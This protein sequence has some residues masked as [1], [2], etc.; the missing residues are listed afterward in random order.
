MITQA[1][2]WETRAEY[3]RAIDLYLRVTNEMTN[4][5]ELL[6][7]V[8]TKALELAIKF[9]KDRALSIAHEVCKRLMEIEAY[10]TVRK[11]SL[12][13]LSCRFATISIRPDL[14]EILRY[15]DCKLFSKFMQ[16]NFSCT[17]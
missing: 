3:N 6:E 12:P 16:T 7:E 11:F 14:R 15:I 5:R 10:E 9:S 4:N 13:K 8:Y 2:D 17:T 1:R